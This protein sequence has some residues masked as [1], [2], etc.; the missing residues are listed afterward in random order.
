MYGC[1]ACGVMLTSGATKCFGCEKCKKRRGG[2]TIG[3]GSQARCFTSSRKAHLV[4]VQFHIWLRRLRGGLRGRCLTA[5]ALLHHRRGGNVGGA[6]WKELS[7]FLK[8]SFNNLT[9]ANA[10]LSSR[11]SCIISHAIDSASAEERSFPSARRFAS[12]SGFGFFAVSTTGGWFPEIWFS[13]FSL[14][15]FS[16]PTSSPL[17]SGPNKFTSAPA[18]CAFPVVEPVMSSS[19]RAGTASAERA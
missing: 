5:T 17:S 7:M 19:P 10:L 6:T 8:S 4:H 11:V 18:A 14:L 13:S 9:Y 12:P 3:T 15:K 1:T 16:P 2:G